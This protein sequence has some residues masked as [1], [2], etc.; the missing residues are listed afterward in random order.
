[1]NNILTKEQFVNVMDDIEKARNFCN[2][3]YD[4]IGF[5]GKQLLEPLWTAC[6]LTIQ[7][8]F[9][10]IENDWIG[11]WMW[12]LNFGKRYEDGMIQDD[13]GIIPLATSEDLYNLLKS[14]MSDENAK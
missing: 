9:N 14:N 10:D 4:L 7:T 13:N 5:G 3:F 8:M 11:Y 12:E 1:M 6:E 2:K